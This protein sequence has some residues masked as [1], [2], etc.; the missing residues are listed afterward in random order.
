[1]KR[2]TKNRKV[3]SRN[4]QYY[5][6]YDPF[7]EGDCKK[8]DS[9]YKDRVSFF[10]GEF[11]YDK[12]NDELYEIKKTGRTRLIKYKNKLFIYDYGRQCLEMYWPDDNGNIDEE[13]GY[14]TYHF[15]RDEW[16]EFPDHCIEDFYDHYTQELYDLY[17]D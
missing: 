1:M 2:L 15:Y 7:K 3:M 5:N 11:Y 8:I 13:E 12:D 4:E 6:L 9:K 10:N 17:Y 16:I 14:E